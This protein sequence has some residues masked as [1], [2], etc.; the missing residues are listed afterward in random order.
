MMHEHAI[1]V[2]CICQEVIESFGLV[3]DPQQKMTHA[4]VMT[5]ALTLIATFQWGRF[6][7]FSSTS[8]QK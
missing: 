8:S 4:E 2:F 6:E 5:F 7:F 1:A 3:D